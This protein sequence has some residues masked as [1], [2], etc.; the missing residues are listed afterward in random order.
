MIKFEKAIMND[1][2]EMVNSYIGTLTGV[3]DEFWEQHV[4]DGD[5]YIIKC[6]NSIIGFYTLFVEWDK[7][8]YIT[9]FYVSEKY[10][11]LAQE[12]MKRIISDFTVEKAYVATCD[13]MFLSVCLDFHKEVCLQAYF[14]DG[15]IHHDVQPAEYAFECMKK[16]NVDEMP[17]IRELT[18][19]FYDDLSDEGISLGEFELYRLVKD[20]ETLGV[21]V[22]VPNKL[23]KGYAA[24]GE[25]VLEQHR[26]KGVA[27]SLQLNMAEIC[28]RNGLIPIGGCWYGNIA[29]KRTFDSCG[30][31]SRTRLLNVT[32]M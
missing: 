22:M 20:G 24:C 29:S 26:R 21:G 25:I 13:E 12:A 11:G 18:G 5:F 28:R 14:F 15:T 9:S 7:K 32:F 31:Y 30:R 3:V 2:M 19:D 6:D 17:K 8:I 27:R 4:I 23:Q 16:V 10:T 1:F